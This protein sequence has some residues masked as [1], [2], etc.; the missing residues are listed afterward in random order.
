MSDH[1]YSKKPSSASRR[2]T[3][4]EEVRGIKLAYIVDTGVFSK[5]GLDFGSRLLLENFTE[6]EAP[7]IILDVGCGWGP[8]GLTIA[9]LYPE[10]MVHLVD[11]NERSIELTAENAKH[12]KIK[13]TEVY[14]QDLLDGQKPESLAAVVTNPPIRAG[15]ATVFRLYEQAYEALKSGGELTVV[16][17]KKQGAPSTL[18]KLED[19]GFE[20]ETKAKKKGYFIFGAKK[21]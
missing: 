5:R 21:Y 1:Y 14:E 7:G 2:E 15:K 16:I 11:V 4:H 13:N 9:S 3:I 10:R 18:Q 6:P 12:N 20:V 19:L 17:Q 8:L